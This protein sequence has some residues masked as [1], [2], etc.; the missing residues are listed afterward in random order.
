MADDLVQR[1]LAE[2]EI[3]VDSGAKLADVAGAEQELV[4]G[5]FG[6]RRGLAKSRNKELGPTMHRNGVAC[7]P[8]RR[9]DAKG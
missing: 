9:P 7:F 4:A 6:V 3:G 1:P 8:V 2:E 5:D